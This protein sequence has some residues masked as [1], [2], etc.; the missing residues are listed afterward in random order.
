M[1]HNASLL[2]PSLARRDSLTMTSI[3]VHL[4]NN[5]AFSLQSNPWWSLI[6]CPSFRFHQT[7]LRWRYSETTIEW[8]RGEMMYWKYNLIRPTSKVLLFFISFHFIFMSVKIYYI[9]IRV[10]SLKIYFL[11]NGKGVTQLLN[12]H[13]CFLFTFPAAPRTSKPVDL[14][15]H[16]CYSI[17]FFRKVP[18][19]Y[20]VKVINQELT[21][22]S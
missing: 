4:R 12:F 6:H 18:H 1:N 19:V 16:L 15:F 2:I 22:L 9:T 5:I 13:Q 20:H 10:S 8:R 14:W 11:L 21:R 17:N 7:P 3:F